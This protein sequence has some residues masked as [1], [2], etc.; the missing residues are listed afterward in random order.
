[1]NFSS[2]VSAENDADPSTA[3]IGPTEPQG[4]DTS[5]ANN[6]QIYNQQAQD[7]EANLDIVAP[8]QPIPEY[9]LATNDFNPTPQDYSYNGVLDEFN[10]NYYMTYDNIYNE[11]TGTGKVLLRCQELIPK[12]VEEATTKAPAPV[13]SEKR[14]CHCN[15][16]CDCSNWIDDHDKLF[17]VLMYLCPFGCFVYECCCGRFHCVHYNQ[18]CCLGGAILNIAFY[19]GVSFLIFTIVVYATH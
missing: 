4:I 19:V 3:L 9:F 8:N 7:I 15:C 12:P 2:R 11:A 1:M 17:C 6:D 13:Q 18:C 14:G 5:I 16:D 10:P